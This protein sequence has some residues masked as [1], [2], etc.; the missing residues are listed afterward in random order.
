MIGAVRCARRVARYLNVTARVVVVADNA[1][2]RSF[3]ASGNIQASDQRM[4]AV[5]NGYPHQ[6]MDI[7][8]EV[9]FLALVAVAVHLSL[10]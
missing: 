3:V 6:W 1:A 9:T 4:T 10:C 2:L 8:P 5:A 7:V